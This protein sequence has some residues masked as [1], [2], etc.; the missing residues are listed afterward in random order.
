MIKL[1]LQKQLDAAS[2]TMRLEIDLSF[3]AGQLVALYGK[4][5]AGKTSILRMLAGLMKPD[6]GK[7]SFG[8]DTWF[9]TNQGLNLKPQ[10]RKV[11]FVFQ[12]YALFPNMTV[13]Q[14]LRFALQR[15]Q[16]GN[17]IDEL[18][19]LVELEGLRHKKPT[20]LSGGQQQRVALARALVQRP[21]LLLLDEPL[22]AIDAE[23]RLK[24]QQY[25]R[26]L[27]EAF[28]LTTILVSHNV[29]EVRNMADQ[30]FCIEEGKITH[31]GAPERVFLSTRISQL[32]ALITRLESRPEG[33]VAHL[34]LDGQSLQVP[35]PASAKWAVGD[36]VSLEIEK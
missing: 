11:G 14:N 25:I 30:V 22:S 27:H 21:A 10:K 12:D 29:N 36:W 6:R 33:K 17:V 13:E 34:D 26:R 19:E 28:G 20:K 23:L 32:K 31:S 24:L 15:H 5:G 9:D 35:V 1:Q 2:G 8:H 18:V 4:S 16:S 3:E 7:I